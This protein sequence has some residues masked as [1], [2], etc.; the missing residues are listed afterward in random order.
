MRIQ[1]MKNDDVDPSRGERISI[2]CP[3]CDEWIVLVPAERA[4]EA[5]VHAMDV[6]Y[7][8]AMDVI[9]SFRVFAGICVCEATITVTV[10]RETSGKPRAEA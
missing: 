3:D 2:E 1:T 8:G 4:K 10:T 6:T 7:P 9:D 5:A